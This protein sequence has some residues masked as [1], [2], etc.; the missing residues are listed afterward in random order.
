M[1]MESYRTNLTGLNE[2]EVRALFMF[3]VPGLLAELGAAKDSEKAMLK[4]TASLPAPFQQDAKMVRE[5]LLLDPAGWFH[6]AEP[7]PYLALLQDAVWHNRRVRIDYR[8]GDGRWVKRLI[9]PYALVAKASIWYVVCAIYNG[10]VMVYRVSR[11]MEASLTGTIFT[12][13]D[14]LNLEAYWHEWRERFEHLQ[15]RFSAEV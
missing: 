9:D 15:T 5:R 1:L 8:R 14:D 6:D 4:L 7:V 12:R 10:S 11:I 3:T 2:S 13:P